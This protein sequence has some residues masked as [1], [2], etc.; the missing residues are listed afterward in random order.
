MYVKPNKIKDMVTKEKP[1]YE[2]LY[3]KEERKLAEHII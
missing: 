2:Q 3:T 1:V